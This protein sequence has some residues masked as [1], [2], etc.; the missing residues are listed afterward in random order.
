MVRAGVVHHLGEWLYG[1]YHEIQNPKQRY[2]L[3]NRQKL[4]ALLGNKDK[5]Q[6][7]EYH[8]NRVEPVLKRGQRPVVLGTTEDGGPDSGN[9]IVRDHRGAY[10]LRRGETHE[11]ATASRAGGMRMAP[12]RC[13]DH[14]CWRPLI[15]TFFQRMRFEL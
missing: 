13:R 1:G 3:I 9:P 12:G 2:W 15:A 6:L 10:G 14:L 4:T 8:R 7:S 5:A 11:S